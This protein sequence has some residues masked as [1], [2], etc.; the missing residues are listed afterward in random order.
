MLLRARIVLPVS[1][2]PIED[3]AVRISGGRITFAGR[4]KDVPSSE[5]TEVFDLGEVILLP[6]LINAHC[7]LDYTHMAGLIP[8][9]RD[10]SHWIKSIVALK[11]S[12]SA[13]EFKAS[14]LTGAEAL[15]RGG[16]TTVADVEA[17][18]E[19]IPALWQTTP[20]RVISFRELIHFRDPRGAREM[21]NKAVAE[22]ANLPDT[23]DRVGLSP[24]APYTTSAELLR[25][26][27]QE[28][29]R[30]RW[31]LTTHVAES[32]AEY[33]MFVSR[34]GLLHEWLK[35]QRD[36]SDCG[37]GSPVQHLDRCGYLGED[38]LA[39]HANYLWMGDADLL[40]RH[41][42]SV[43]HCPRS[44]AYF[45]HRRFPR[46][47][48]VETGVN[49]CLGTDSMAT[50]IIEPGSLTELSLFSEMRALAGQL[51]APSPEFIVNM[52]T[53]NGARA[54]G[55]QGEL[56]ELVPGARADL[57]TIPFNETPQDVWAAVVHHSGPVKVSMMD[58]RWVIPPPQMKTL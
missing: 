14:W 11:G 17:L 48:L 58:G 37:L 29:R 36:M 45:G 32:E 5:R 25:V 47:Q 10:F 52:A 33:E 21:V 57:I 55:W 34:C 39:V 46:E 8:Q 38:L 7:H 20:L 31:R 35:S 42:V 22:W 19:L 50:V 9:P 15:L 18:P 28:A 26:A 30:R 2:P 44:H 3:G 53:L 23:S 13:E 54:L 51:R 41:R 16:V 12:W 40:A 27:A 6:G 4:W 43:V 24:H 49:V 56:G 1:K